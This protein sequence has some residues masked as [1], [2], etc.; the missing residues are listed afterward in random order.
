[1]ATEAFV[2]FTYWGKHSNDDLNIL[3]V[4]NSNRYN[5]NLTPTLTDKTAEIPGGD[6]MY[7]FNTYHKQKQFTINIAF[8]S[9]TETQLR[10]LRQVFDGKD[11]HDLVFDEL[12]DRVYHAKVTSNPNIKYI[13][14]DVHDTPGTSSNTGAAVAQSSTTHVIYKGE[15]TIQF[16]CYDPYAYGTTAY[17]AGD[18]VCGE[19]ETPFII[20]KK[21]NE[22]GSVIVAAGET[23]TVTWGGINHTIT[24]P[25]AA[26]GTT[27]SWNSSTGMVKA[28]NTPLKFIGNSMLMLPVGSTPV[29]NCSDDD[30]DIV[31]TLTYYNRYY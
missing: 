28:D 10:T 31:F 2:G 17:H 16:T 13:P 27:I 25:N 22:G 11:I 7:F 29:A 8:D 4:S 14:F 18:T 9:L 24:F 5:D 6:G 21:D 19:V 1:M 20:T 26:T 15:G 23:W 12:P 30:E 3:R